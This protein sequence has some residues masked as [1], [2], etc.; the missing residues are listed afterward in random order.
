MCERPR[1]RW[2]H[3]VETGAFS[4]FAS[5]V[6]DVQEPGS[7]CYPMQEISTK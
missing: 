7:T 4:S 3:T 1:T 2:S 5:L 6:R